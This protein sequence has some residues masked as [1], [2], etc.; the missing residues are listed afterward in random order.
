VDFS[1]G[2]VLVFIATENLHRRQL[3]VSQR[4][5]VAARIK[6][7]MRGEDWRGIAAA[8]LRQVENI[9]Q[10]DHRHNLLRDH[11]AP[12]TVA[13]AKSLNVSLRSVESA[14]RV[15]DKG[16]PE[17]QKAVVDGKIKVSKAADIASLPEAEQHQHVTNLLERRFTPADSRRVAKDNSERYREYNDKYPRRALKKLRKDYASLPKAEQAEFMASLSVMSLD[18]ILARLED[19]YDSERAT[20]A[21]KAFSEIRT[22]KEKLRVDEVVAQWSNKHAEG[23]ALEEEQSYGG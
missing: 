16:A 23:D 20:I 14:D 13:V 5:M 6:R 15:V 3:N 2:N 18:H 8:N 7:A 1:G 9:E 11:T 4:S 10:S 22:D 17:L 21:I 12:E 19:L